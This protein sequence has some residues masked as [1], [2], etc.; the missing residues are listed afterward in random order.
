[1]A[2]SPLAILPPALLARSLCSEPTRA[3]PSPR[4]RGRSHIPRLFQKRVPSAQAFSET[5][6]KT[7]PFCLHSSEA[8]HFTADMGALTFWKQ[9]LEFGFSSCFW[10]LSDMIKIKNKKIQTQAAIAGGAGGQPSHSLSTEKL[11]RD[12]EMEEGQDNQEASEAPALGCKMQLSA[13]ILLPVLTGAL[14]CFLPALS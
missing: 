10:K 1:M 14:T 8:Y 11:A 2:C 9:C 4:G 7:Y 12:T 13:G 3:R 5:H 6:Q